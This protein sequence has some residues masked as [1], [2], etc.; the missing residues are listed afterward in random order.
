VNLEYLVNLGLLKLPEH[1]DHQQFLELLE[2]LCFLPIQKLQKLKFQHYLIM[3]HLY[4]YTTKN[5]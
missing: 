4:Q 2:V 3:N 5:L 1:L